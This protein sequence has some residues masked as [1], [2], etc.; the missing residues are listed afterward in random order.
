M[1]VTR[2]GDEVGSDQVRHI[3]TETAERSRA[4]PGEVSGI[5]ESKHS[6]RTLYVRFRQGVL[7][8]DRDVN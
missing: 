1:L 5:S 8:R 4:G 6:F 2:L 3:E 7:L